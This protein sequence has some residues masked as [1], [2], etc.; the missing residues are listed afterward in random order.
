VSPS[1]EMR[2]NSNL[3]VLTKSSGF[4]MTIN[5]VTSRSQNLVLIGGLGIT[6]NF[7]T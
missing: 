2:T 5:Q 6:K 7:V 4:E 3:N 1:R